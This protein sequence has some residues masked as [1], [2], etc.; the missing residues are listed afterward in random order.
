MAIQFLSDGV[1][2]AMSADGVDGVQQQRERWERKRGRTSRE[3]VRTEQQYCLRLELL[4]TY[5]VKILKA[6]GT[7][8]QDIMESI[9]SSI[10]SIHLVNQALLAY[11]EDEKLGLGFER[12][13]PHLNHYYT[14]VDNF[15][16]ASKVL[17]VQVK[18]NKAFR[19]FK[20]LQE[21]RP[22]FRSS[23]LEELLQLPLQRVQQYKHFLR[24]LAENTSPDH[25]EFPQLSGAVKAISAVAQRIQ[26][27]ARSQENHLQLLR[28][29]K[30]LKGRK[31]KVLAPGRWY[32]REG[33]LKVVPTKGT[34]VKPKMFFLFS[35]VLLL[36][37]PCSA[38]HPT[39]GDKFAC[40]HA[41]PL[42]ECTVDKVFGHT[43]SQGGLISLTFAKDKL[44]LMS[45]DQED[46][47]DWYRSLTS[48]I[49]QLMSRN[50][51]VHGR[52]GLS[53]KPLRSFEGLTEPNTPTAPSHTRKRVRVSVEPQ[54]QVGD[55]CSV[56]PSGGA[57]R[58]GASKRAK[59]STAGAE[60]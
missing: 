22:E 19:R 45:G 37:A 11:L 58:A 3:L 44:L 1:S 2:V 35:D 10:T 49:G 27:N 40:R 36:T 13:C 21:S 8:Q 30:L 29:Q 16:K 7:L 32:V 26:D 52:D 25:H 57:E 53:R 56:P 28:V 41:Y 54:G 50:T 18:K 17:Q 34:E 46:I 9:F 60:R 6:K 59:L 12:F 20:K 5:F 14:Y 33:W 51:T 55:P 43:R 38:L 39:N 31:T 23:T 24:D 48:A 47:N 15:E 4:V 42:R